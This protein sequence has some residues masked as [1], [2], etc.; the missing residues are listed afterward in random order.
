MKRLVILL[1]ISTFLSCENGDIIPNYGWEDITIEFEKTDHTFMEVFSSAELWIEDKCYLYSEA[2]GKGDEYILFDRSKGVSNI[3]SGFRIVPIAF[4]DG[5][6]REY[7]D[8]R[9]SFGSL[10]FNPMYYEDY[11]LTID[12]DIITI[13]NVRIPDSVYTLR[14]MAYDENNVLL[15][16]QRSYKEGYEYHISHYV[17][18][19]PEQGWKNDYMSSEEFYK[20]LEEL[21]NK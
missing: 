16:W 1:I 3:P 13:K 4:E 19:T 2:G 12:G 9:S 17:K 7:Y 18:N 14:V 8:R 20:K 6:Y 15:E 11:N 5:F 10:D 21:G